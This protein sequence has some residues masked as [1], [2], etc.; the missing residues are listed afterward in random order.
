MVRDESVRERL[1]SVRSS[2]LV[3]LCR[4]A[5]P[6]DWKDVE[7]LCSCQSKPIH[8]S[9]Q[10]RGRLEEKKGRGERERDLFSFEEG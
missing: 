10:A 4:S 8:R 2:L 7:D 9:N 6:A 3:D 5:S 1:L